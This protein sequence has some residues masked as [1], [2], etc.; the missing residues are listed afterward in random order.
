MTPLEL[1]N[2]LGVAML[3]VLGALVFRKLGLPEWMHAV[4]P[5]VI[6][7]LIFGA[8][9]DL[10]DSQTTLVHGVISGLLASGILYIVLGLT[11]KN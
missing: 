1:N 10:P 11:R 5:T 6:C 2:Q 4:I 7:V 8:F 9:V 3:A